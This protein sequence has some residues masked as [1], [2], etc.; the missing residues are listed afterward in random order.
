MKL[1]KKTAAIIVAALMLA[2]LAGCGLS[3]ENFGGSG[4][5][6]SQTPSSSA[7]ATP[8]PA[9]TV[10]VTETVTAKPAPS[11]EASASAECPSEFAQ[12]AVGHDK[13]RVIDDFAERVA[14]YVALAGDEKAGALNA[15][16]TE[17]AKNAQVLAIWAYSVGLHDSPDNWK[18]LV[19]STD[20]CLSEAGRSLHAAFAGA[21]Q[22]SAATGGISF[23]EAPASGHNTG[24]DNEGNFGVDGDSG[25]GGD[26][27]A[28][29]TVL[30]DG[31]VAYIMTRCA[32][33]VYP[34]KPARLPEVPTDNPKPPEEGGEGADRPS[35]KP[36]TRP[37][38]S[39]RPTTSA[40]P[41]PKASK[42]PSR[43]P[44]PQGNNKTGGGGTVP[45]WSATPAPSAPAGGNPPATYTPPATTQAPAPVVKPSTR[46][47]S[48]PTPTVAPS[49]QPPNHGVIEVPTVA[50]SDTN[51]VPCSE[52]DR[53]FGLC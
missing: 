36:T 27:E 51:N 9:A 53:E 47:S 43:D 2:P 39:S 22:A 6:P 44:E 8:V 10:I 26:R 5:S 1:N 35:T 29:K 41:T 20:T 7:T 34:G 45:T 46:P 40:T 31:S 12:E 32:N 3:P 18:E 33:P 49:T 16:V 50:P 25:I 28:I 30:L 37:S 4:G 42:V 52:S 15:L 23:D 38:T 11:S 14:D 21:V 48:E 24:V 17:S 13:N 19:D